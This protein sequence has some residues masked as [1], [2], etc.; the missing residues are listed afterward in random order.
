MK[1]S[2]SKIRQLINEV[3]ES[4][5]FAN[6]ANRINFDQTPIEINTTNGNI[7][8]GGQEYSLKASTAVGEAKVIVKDIKKVGEEIQIRA[9]GTV[10]LPFVGE[11]SQEKTEFLTPAA[12]AEIRS[13][14]SQGISPFTI[15]PE[16]EDGNPMTFTAV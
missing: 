9:K 6:E 14:V 2:K 4:K 13:N 1:V 12:V 16:K 7:I 15:M 11:K 3:I 5:I 8:I 10:T